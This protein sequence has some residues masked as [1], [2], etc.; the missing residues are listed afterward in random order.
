MLFYSFF[1]ANRSISM[2]FTGTVL[3]LTLIWR[4]V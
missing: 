3:G 4:D 1:Y 2:L